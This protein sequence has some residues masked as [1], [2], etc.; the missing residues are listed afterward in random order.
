MIARSFAHSSPGCDPIGVILTFCAS[1]GNAA[2][3]R[4]NAAQAILM[5]FL[6]GS[7]ILVWPVV[8]RQSHPPG[9]RLSG[10]ADMAGDGEQGSLLP[11]AAHFESFAFGLVRPTA[12]DPNIP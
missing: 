3:K 10:A 6:L 11:T 9:E 12:P 4:A 2:S 7:L 8:A 1:A 5:S